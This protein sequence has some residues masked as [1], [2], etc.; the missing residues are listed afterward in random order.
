LGNDEASR[1]QEAF[2]SVGYGLD[3]VLFV[4]AK[5]A[6]CLGDEDIAEL[7]KAYFS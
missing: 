7:R 5:G 4:K 2:A 3:Y 1:F 6:K